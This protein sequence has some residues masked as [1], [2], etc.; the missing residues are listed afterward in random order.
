M[1]ARRCGGIRVRRQRLGAG[2]KHACIWC[3]CV[4]STVVGM[5]AC[6]AVPTCPNQRSAAVKKSDKEQPLIDD[7]RLLGRMLGDGIRE[8]RGLRPSS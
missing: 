3:M 8:R 2:V 6:M 1:G 4:P 5:L 7:I